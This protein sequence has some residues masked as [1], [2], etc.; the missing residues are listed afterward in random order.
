MRK[1]VCTRS[2]VPFLVGIFAS[3][4][5]VTAKLPMNR[6][7]SPEA[8]GKAFGGE[9]QLAYQ[10]RNEVELTP[11]YETRAPNLNDP[12]VQKPGHRV[13]S[14]TSVGL[15]ERMEI[16]LTLLQPRLG[17]KYQFLGD[18]R[19]KA[20]KGNFS[21]ALSAGAAGSSEKEYSAGTS[22]TPATSYE[23]EE[24]F[25]DGALILGWRLGT[26]A[27]LYGGPFWVS[28]YLKTIYTS[29]TGTPA[30]NSSGRIDSYG[31]NFGV[32]AHVEE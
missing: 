29:G 9:V 13:I 28:D 23:L 20:S 3:S 11:A 31:M 25:V 2:W 16:S 5:A 24:T 10:G 1:L 4:C 6:F 17:L 21:M 30:V 32:Q 18:T 26:D 12:S 14:Q 15:M 22:V 7:E 27:L 8:S 19:P